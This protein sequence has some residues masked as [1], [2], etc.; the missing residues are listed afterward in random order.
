MSD[1]FPD[2]FSVGG[3]LF[4]SSMPGWDGSEMAPSVL[5]QCR[6]TYTQLMQGLIDRKIDARHVARLDHYTASQSWLAERQQIRAT[7]FGEPCGLASTGVAVHHPAGLGVT[8]A[9]I[10][11]LERQSVTSVSGAAYGMP[12]IATSVELAGHLFVSG[13]LKTS[14]DAWENVR[15][16][17]AEIDEIVAPFRTRRT[18]PVR[19]DVFAGSAE[20][21]PQAQD[22]IFKAFGDECPVFSAVLPF[23]RDSMVEITS[24]FAEQGEL[25]ALPPMS[26]TME[27]IARHV[28]FHGDQAKKSGKQIA[29]LDFRYPP[30]GEASVRQLFDSIH[31]SHPPACV[32]FPGIGSLAQTSEYGISGFLA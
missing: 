24:L 19:F 13:I 16:A 21:I 26:G 9:M 15:N 8:C 4:S 27:A 5:E 23:A 28:N 29:R 20:M 7:F 10:A 31:L 6:R 17:V 30:G 32:R 1:S 25:I 14:L 11:H 2:F 3:F 12:A 18:R 22:E